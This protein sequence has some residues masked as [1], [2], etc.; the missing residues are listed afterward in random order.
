MKIQNKESVIKLSVKKQVNKLNI[1]EE[2]D[3]YLGEYVCCSKTAV[4][5]A[6]AQNLVQECNGIYKEYWI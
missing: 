3:S 5:K 6:G 1:L 2:N 4:K